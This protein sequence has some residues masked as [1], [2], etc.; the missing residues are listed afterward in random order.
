MGKNTK[1]TFGVVILSTVLGLSFAS[2]YV[3]NMFHSDEDI[4]MVENQSPNTAV[5]SNYHN[6]N[7]TAKIID[8]SGDKKEFNK[9]EFSSVLI[10]CEN[11]KKENFLFSLMDFSAELVIPYSKSVNYTCFHIDSNAIGCKQK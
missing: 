5:I 11:D 7:A 8:S 4:K 10:H 6:E 9:C 2:I 3:L 1:E